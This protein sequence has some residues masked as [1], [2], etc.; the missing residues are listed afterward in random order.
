MT[1]G[2]LE[3]SEIRELLKIYK[4]CLDNGLK[5]QTMELMACPLEFFLEMEYLD[6]LMDQI[7][8][9]FLS[10]LTNKSSLCAFEGF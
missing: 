1:C 8:C 10:D 9:Y 7:M 3:K 4:Y 2:V 5:A 6:C